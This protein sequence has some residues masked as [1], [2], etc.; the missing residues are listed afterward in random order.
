ML[1]CYLYPNRLRDEGNMVVKTRKVVFYE[2][3]ETDQAKCASPWSEDRWKRLFEDIKQK[4]AIEEKEGSNSTLLWNSF[5]GRRYH[6]S[7]RSC[8]TPSVDYL[9]LCKLR[10][11]ID[12]PD[13]QN[14]GG[15][16]E[17]LV[18]KAAELGI[19]NILEPCYILPVAGTRYIAVMRSSNGPSARAISDWVDSFIDDVKTNRVFA[20]NPVF[21]KDALKRLRTAI[22]AKR[23][24]F[25]FT[26]VPD[27][28]L[29]EKIEGSHVDAAVGELSQITKREMSI[30]VTLSFGH[31]RALGPGPDEMLEEVKKIVD[32]SEKPNRKLSKLEAT[33]VQPGDE[34]PETDPIDFLKEKYCE[35]VQVGASENDEP[36][37]ESV[38]AAMMD[39]ITKFRKKIRE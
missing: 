39:A 7:A 16:V 30:G 22:G 14:V 5:G 38:L 32:A 15:S 2:G 1:S 35:T 33:V 13:V 24:S 18:S 6:C 4:E 36:S 37:P 10:P 23:L 21:T 29:D 27:A 8:T 3:V 12:W 25:A 19:T 26:E 31:A 17:S 34:H 28:D 9:Y 20:L 11:R